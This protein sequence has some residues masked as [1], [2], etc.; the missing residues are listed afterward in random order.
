[1]SVISGSFIRTEA[2]KGDIN[3]LPNTKEQDAL[4]LR[5]PSAPP[6]W[7]RQSISHEGYSQ[8]SDL[9]PFA[10]PLSRGLRE[11]SA[12]GV[13]RTYPKHRILNHEQD[14]SGALYLILSGKIKLYMSDEYG[15]EF[16]LNIYHP[17]EYFGELELIDTGPCLTS[18]MAL[19]LSQLCVISQAGFR[20]YL[21]E[22]P[23]AAFDLLHL[24]AQRTRL[25]TECVKSLALD[26]V[27]RRVTRTLL[28]LASEREGQFVIEDRLT[29]KDLADR[30]GASREMVSRIMKDLQAG[31]YIKVKGE[32]I[33]IEKRLPLAW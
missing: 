31:G 2:S 10:K 21:L 19:E 6:V 25:L 8:I 17:G 15:K 13:V 3:H 30:V 16:I 24:L 20:C 7:G 27:Y 29:H 33:T 12:Y 14:P 32:K 28:R 11:L 22:H 9:P 26:S 4:D 5:T 1:M 18:A 23:E